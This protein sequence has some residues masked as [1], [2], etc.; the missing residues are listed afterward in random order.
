MKSKA[1]IIAALFLS[2][3]LFARL[4]FLDD[5]L[6]KVFPP[7]T[8]GYS[9]FVVYG[10]EKWEITKTK[11]MPNNLG[12]RRFAVCVQAV[13]PKNQALQAGACC[14]ALFSMEKGTVEFSDAAEPKL[15]FSFSFKNQQVVDNLK[16]LLNDCASWTNWY[17]SAGAKGA[18]KMGLFDWGDHR[19]QYLLEATDV[20]S[21]S[22]FGSSPSESLNVER[23]SLKIA[24]Y[25][26]P[27]AA[28]DNNPFSSN[29]PTG[30]QSRPVGRPEA[31]ICEA[32]A[33]LTILNSIDD[34][35]V[36]YKSALDGESQQ[37]I[38]AQKRAVESAKEAAEQQVTAEQEASARKLA[39]F[40]SKME[41]EKAITQ[42]EA[43]KNEKVEAI[44]KEEQEKQIEIDSRIAKIIKDRLATQEGIKIC[45]DIESIE[46]KIAKQEEKVQQRQADE[47]E[48]VNDLQ[49]KWTEA[50]A[51]RAKTVAAYGFEHSLSIRAKQIE[52]DAQ[53]DFAMAAQNHQD[54]SK[55]VG[56][57]SDL[58]QM[59]SDLN[60]RKKDLSTYCGYSYEVVK[61][62]R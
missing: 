12:E 16:L 11:I 20:S 51:V 25:P 39:E 40:Q 29:Q 42:I 56:L 27:A 46:D 2:F 4:E 19:S 3:R 54:S 13:I 55:L 22:Q 43:Q 7:P 23:M 8:S 47:M 24:F 38:L 59:K 28:S 10:D 30:R 21:Q 6:V 49:K 17:N 31:V 61:K 32:K 1:L 57:K 41:A 50:T 37:L 18:E 15:K 60:Q 48:V 33:L 14:Q 45:R 26:A 44:K 34:I 53:G 62:F 52:R 35:K 9:P 58:E 36:K 5:G